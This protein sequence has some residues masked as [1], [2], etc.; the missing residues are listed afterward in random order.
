VPAEQVGIAERGAA[1]A[2]TSQNGSSTGLKPPSGSL[3]TTPRGSGEP[4]P[5]ITHEVALKIIAKKKVKGNEASV[6]GEMEVLRGL[7]HPNIVCRLLSLLGAE[8]LHRSHR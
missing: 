5:G 4:S 2:S 7:D 3:P 1:G 6:W 8:F